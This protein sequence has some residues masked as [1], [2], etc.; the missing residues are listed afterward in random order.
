MSVQRLDHAAVFAHTRRWLERAVIGLNLCPFAK[1]VYA[2][3]QVHYAVY[4]GVDEADFL[5]L[6]RVQLAEL[7]AA[8]PQQRDTTLLIAPL[9]YPEFLDFNAMLPRAQRVL[10]KSGLEGV[11]Q[12]ASFHPGY[13]FAEAAPDD[14]AHYTN[15]APYPIFHL[16]REDAVARAVADFAQAQTIFER[17]RA[18]LR[19]LGPA[20]WNALECGPLA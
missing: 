18:T 10:R 20:G 11:L 12:I 2:K 6:L 8:E 4:D 13:V 16:L 7:D 19:A 15:R 9:L 5:A 14:M 1:S 3:E 17:N